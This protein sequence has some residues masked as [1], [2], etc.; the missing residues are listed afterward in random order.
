MRLG[1]VTDGVPLREDTLHQLRPP[2]GVPS[3][4][5]ENRLAIE[6]AKQVEYARRVI[7]IGAVVESEERLWE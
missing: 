2:C 7:G 3:D 1:V 6:F 4:Y 5:K